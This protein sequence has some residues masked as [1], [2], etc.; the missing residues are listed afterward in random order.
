MRRLAG[1]RLAGERLLNSLCRA[2]TAPAGMSMFL[3]ERKLP[4]ERMMVVG[5]VLASP[6]LLGFGD[7]PFHGSRSSVGALHARS[8]PLSSLHLTQLERM[9]ALA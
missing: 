1:Y 3:E 9:D 7:V 5:R 2:F 4:E 6:E 8:L